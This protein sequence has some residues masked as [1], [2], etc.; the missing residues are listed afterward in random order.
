MTTNDSRMDDLVAKVQEV[1]KAVYTV[2]GPGH[3]ESVY[4]LAMSVEL[5]EAKIP[6]KQE[7]SV[8]VLYKGHWVGRKEIDL[9]VDNRL[10]VELK[11][12]GS[13]SDNHK[14]QAIAQSKAAEKAS[15]LIHFRNVCD[16]NAMK[17]TFGRDGVEVWL[18][19]E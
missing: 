6:F 7:Q 3:E 16:N 18:K 12:T 2:L 4:R 10:A 8:D 11:S 1:S 19:D 17:L 5:R 14:A 9:L 13:A 15:M